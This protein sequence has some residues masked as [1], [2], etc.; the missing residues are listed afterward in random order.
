MRD[1]AAAGPIPVCLIGC[2]AATR[3]Y[4]VPALARLERQGT[5]RIV[6]IFDPDPAAIAAVSDTLGTSVPATSTEEAFAPARLAIIASSPAL[7][8]SQTIEALQQGLDVFCETPIALASA[9]ADAMLA[10][11]ADAGRH[12]TVGLVR[13]NL[14]A[15]R[16]IHALLRANALGA[17][18][19]MDWFEGGPLA[20]LTAP[21]ACFSAARPRG[22]VIQD[23][24][25]HALDLLAW[26]CGPPTLE[27][28]EDDAMGGVEANA[29]L[30]L[31]CGTARVAMRL[32][33]DWARPNR[34]VI[35]GDAGSLSW[36]V[37]DPVEV[38]LELAGGHPGRLVLD[39]GAEDEPDLVT[40]YAA[41]LK[42]VI[43][44]IRTGGTPMVPAE[45]GRDVCALIEACHAARKPIPMPWLVP[46]GAPA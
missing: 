18:R 7:R 41:Q 6:T 10:V 33:H 37:D 14:P 43:E 13:R 9:D 28:C 22:G 26:W 27:S 24:G 32:S 2:G 23:I 8:P 35:R 36:S 31:R 16:T 21:P 29:R 5:A 19:S 42:D 40:S 20:V 12:L 25:S 38:G 3:L 46:P 11:A 17:L 1:E 15:A 4:A 39:V 44:A 45:A 30:V 34:V